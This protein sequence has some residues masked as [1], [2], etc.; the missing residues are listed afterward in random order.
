MYQAEDF[1]PWFCRFYQVGINKSVYCP[2]V[3]DTVDV[4]SGTNSFRIAV[5][6]E[7]MARVNLRNVKGYQLAWVE[8]RVEEL[9]EVGLL[10]CYDGK[11]NP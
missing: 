10:V 1:Y 2:D 7:T 4:S 8:G 5:S 3:G 11:K 6:D 9:K